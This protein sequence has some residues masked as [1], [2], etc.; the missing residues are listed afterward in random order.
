MAKVLLGVPSGGSVK[1]KTMLTI[2]SILV[3]STHEITLVEREG[4][5]GPDN[6]NHLAR[7]AVE[8]GFAYLFL[9]DADMSFP[10]DTLNRLI[11]HGKELVGAAYNFRGFPLCTVVKLRDEM[12]RVYSPGQLPSDTLFPCYAI[13]SGCKLV[14]TTALLKMP[15][16]W[17]ALGF[18]Q[19]GMLAISDDVWFCNQ[20]RAVGIQ[21]WCDPTIKAGHLGTYTF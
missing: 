10:G 2:I 15:K 20:A 17:F 5:L 4:A 8:G 21:T 14:T 1:S 9:V 13:G 3:Q 12:G 19:D 7:L 6:R 18:G 16:P 11:A